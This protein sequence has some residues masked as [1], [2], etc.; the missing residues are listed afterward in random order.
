MATM[1]NFAALWPSSSAPV[2][3]TCTSGSMAALAI[4]GFSSA[5]FWLAATALTALAWI[6]TIRWPSR[7]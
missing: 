6:N 3:R 2:N 4:Q 7:R 5:I 1:K